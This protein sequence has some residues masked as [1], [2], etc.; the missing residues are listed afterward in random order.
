LRNPQRPCY[1]TPMT[2]PPRT[3]SEI[4]REQLPEVRAASKPRLTVRGFAARLAE[5]GMPLD[6]SIISR[7]EQG[8]RGV[9]LDE[10][11]AFAYALSVTPTRLF[12]PVGRASPVTI[13]GDQSFSPP[14]VRMWARGQRVLDGQD[15]RTWWRETED[16]EEWVGR[17]AVT[18]RVL[19]DALAE[20]TD[21]ANS[22][23]M[24]KYTR[25]LSNM[26]NEIDHAQKANLDRIDL[27][28]D[29]QRHAEIKETK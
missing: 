24:E 21:A 1:A 16:E 17:T 26:G 5:L 28:G 10:A 20:L 12:L 25:A 2:T 15:A 18:F 13:I 8:K 11:L 14:F 29:R 27:L 22:G 4:L 19:N 3:P 23:D 6:P 7:I 9:S